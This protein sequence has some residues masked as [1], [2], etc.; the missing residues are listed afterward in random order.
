MA[1]V[2]YGTKTDIQGQGADQEDAPYTGDLDL[3]SVNSAEDLAALLRV[4]HI[5]SDKPSLR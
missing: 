3:D 4:V 2:R 1:A 5:R